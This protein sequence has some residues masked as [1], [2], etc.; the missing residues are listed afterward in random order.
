M[1]LGVNLAYRDLDGH[2][3]DARGIATRAAAIEEAGF[4]GIW[5]PDTLAVRSQPRPDPLVWLSIAA[6]ST[7]RI[8]LGTSIYIIPFRNPVELAQRVLSLHLVSHE[9]FVM[10]VGAG[11]DSAALTAAGVAFED[12]FKALH[13]NMATVRALCHGEEVDGAFLNPWPETGTG[14][15]MMLGAWHSSVSLG[16]AV[17][18]YDGWICSAG[19]TSLSVMRE[20]LAR[21]R[22]LGGTRAMV[23]SCSVDLSAPYERLDDDDS[24]SLRCPP[25]AAR[26]R[27]QQ[28]VELGFDDL[29]LQV[30]KEGAK[31]WEADATPDELQEIR[32]LLP[33]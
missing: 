13:S 3:L 10:G 31:R 19:R 6:V 1:R 32:S 20:A 4:D 14:P 5:Q 21:Y 26:D 7:T 29:G 17:R 2:P 30:A 24:F 15:Q 25:E 33:A 18:D 22:D 16:R 11:S 28:L 12:R 9:R 27:V 23:G 8:S